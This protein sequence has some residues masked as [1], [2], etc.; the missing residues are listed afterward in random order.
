V[1][2]APE[3]P[4][5][6][7]AVI[8]RG[9]AALNDSLRVLRGTGAARAHA[10]ASAARSAMFDFSGIGDRLTSFADDQGADDW[11]DFWV[12]SVEVS[13]LRA[14]ITALP[15]TVPRITTTTLRALDELCAALQQIAHVHDE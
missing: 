9:I 15:G 4:V 11:D 12:T 2:A 14:H 6:R 13:A 1:S 5:H 10:D 7:Q 8:T 3:Q